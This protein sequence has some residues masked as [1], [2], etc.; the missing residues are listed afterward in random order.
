MNEVQ[1][2]VEKKEK[3]KQEILRGGQLGGDLEAG[4]RKREELYNS[5]C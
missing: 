3:L 2:H 1:E 5:F 4:R